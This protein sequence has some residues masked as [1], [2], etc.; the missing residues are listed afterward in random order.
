M[1]PLLVQGRSPKKVWLPLL[2]AHRLLLGKGPGNTGP[3]SEFATLSYTLERL[4]VSQFPVFPILYAAIS[5]KRT[6]TSRLEG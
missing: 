2:K 5:I 6:P 3:Y 4:K 1:P